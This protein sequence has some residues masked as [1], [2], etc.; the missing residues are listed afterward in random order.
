MSDS[1]FSPAPIV[2]CGDVEVNG[3][4]HFYR[5]VGE[6]E[7]I[8]VLHGGPGMWHDE[9]FPFFDDLTSDHQVVFYDQRGNG[10]SA[11]EEVT[12]DNFTV[13]WLVEDL[14]ALRNVWGF[15][16][17]S[18][19]GHSWGGLLGMYYATRH[20]HRVER[21]VLVDPA[22]PNTDLLIQSYHVLMGRLT[23]DESH[24]LESL[25]GSEAYRAGDPLSHNEAM[26]LSEGVTFHVPEAR[27][28]YF[29]L[30]S[31]DAAS[32]RS[33]VAI[34]GPARTMKLN[35]TVEP[36]LSDIACPTLIIYGE[37]DFIVD[38]A[39]RL[40]H[41]LIHESELVII[42]NSGHYPFIEQP[43]AFSQALRRF[44]TNQPSNPAVTRP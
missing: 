34:S 13:D 22:P 5:M 20:P 33:M 23:Q 32:A 40:V 37:H 4:S 10:K 11:M 16:R 39:P 41:E 6:G 7:P 38:A 2:R 31:F 30:I 21:L 28:A 8:V 29:D 15:E 42:P 27:D 24:R 9:L 14:E 36:H 3:V 43:E 35:I 1:V 19:V 25:Y 18:I 12:A 44:I 17:I 26:R